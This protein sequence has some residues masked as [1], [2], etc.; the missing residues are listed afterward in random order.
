MLQN[1]TKCR[2]F[3]GVFIFLHQSMPLV[4][5]REALKNGVNPKDA[6][7]RDPKRLCLNYVC[8]YTCMPIISL[9]EGAT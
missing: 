3:D 1:L 2:E 4:L 9:E 8:I 5:I 6:D 7:H